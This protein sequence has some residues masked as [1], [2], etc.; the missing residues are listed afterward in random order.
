MNPQEGR[1]FRIAPAHNGKTA[2]GSQPIHE[3]FGN[4]LNWL[5]TSRRDTSN[6]GPRLSLS[7]LARGGRFGSRNGFVFRGTS[8][9][10]FL[11]LERQNGFVW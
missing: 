8:G 9:F 1:E 4:W 5:G 11:G 6:S 7:T 3:A 2:R 10:A